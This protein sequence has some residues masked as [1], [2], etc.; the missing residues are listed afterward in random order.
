MCSILPNKSE[1]LNFI[2][3]VS[4]SSILYRKDCS[5]NAIIVKDRTLQKK[6]K[7]FNTHP[8]EKKNLILDQNK[9]NKYI[10]IIV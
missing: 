5:H 3:G 4:T 9:H 7:R 1:S 8:E 2:R 6:K 10:I